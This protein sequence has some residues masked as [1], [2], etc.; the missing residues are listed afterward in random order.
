MKI[1]EDITYNLDD[2]ID[3]IK[4]AFGFIYNETDDH[5]GYITLDSQSDL[6]LVFNEEEKRLDSATISLSTDEIDITDSSVTASTLVSSIES[7]MQVV[8]LVKRM[9]GGDDYDEDT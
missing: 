4:E 1:V 9:L 6:N 8:D 2:I 5:S 3:Q 7:A